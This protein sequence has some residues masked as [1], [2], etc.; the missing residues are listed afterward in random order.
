[1]AK[2]NE[3]KENKMK[4]ENKVIIITGSTRGIGRAIAESCGKQGGKIVICSRRE[5]AVNETVDT[6]KKKGINISGITADV[7]KGTD[8]EKLL[9]HSID[10]WGKVD[11]WVNNAG[12]SSGMRAIH[13]LHEQE[14]KDVINVNL[15]GTLIACKLILDYFIKNNGGIV[16]NMGGRGSNGNASPFLTTY[17]A[18]KAAVVSLTKSLAKEYKEYPVS[19]NA[20]VPGM[21]ATDFYRDIKIGADQE[22]NL[23]SIPYV[24]KAFGVPAEEVGDFFTEI[25]AQQP[26]KVTGKTYNLLKGG[27]LARGIGLMMYYR[28]TGKIKVSM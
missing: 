18:T 17:A 20:V 7:S 2:E 14:I 1:M 28:A 11:V 3:K 5:E 24:L 15:T 4:L 22:D 25:S 9:Q 16:I 13:E 26:G 6:L 8:L 21:V 10:Q 27:R 19:I 23:E 12:L